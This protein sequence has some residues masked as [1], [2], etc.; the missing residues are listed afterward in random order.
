MVEAVSNAIRT[1]LRRV[2][3]W[4]QII[5]VYGVIAIMVYAW[6]LLWF[7]WR[8]PSWLDF[9]NV[10]EVL[11]QLAYSLATNF[12]ESLIVLCAP[13]LLALLLPRRWFHD[14][15]IARG[16][17]LAIAGLGCL[18]FLANQFDNKNDY[19]T[20]SLHSWTVLLILLAIAVLV[21]LCGRI[22]LLRRVLE[23][24]ADRTSIFAYLLVPLSLISL[25][26]VIVRVLAG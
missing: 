13:V 22:A 2:P 5:P 20:F 10:G 15:F 9:L 1:I 24:L 4:A 18:M 12:I 14:A 16:A 6:T 26:V 19:P 8:L 11:T 23:A 21:Y 7:F 25:L 17:S 3:S